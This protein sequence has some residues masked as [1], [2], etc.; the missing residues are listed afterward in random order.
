[1]DFKTELE[2]K[3]YVI[4][5]NILNTS[6][7]DKALTYFK[8]WQQNIPNHEKFSKNMNPHGIYKFHQAGHTLHAWYIRTLPQVQNIFKQLWNTEELISSFDGSCYIPKNCNKKDTCWTHTDQNGLEDKLKCYQGIVTLT[9]NKERTLVVYEGSHKLHYKYFKD[10]NNTS[11]SNWQKIDPNYLNSISDKKKILNIP[12]GSLVLWDSRTFHQNQYGKPLS[13]ERYVQYVCF[14]PKNHPQNTAAM[15]R[16]RKKYFEDRRTTS[17]WP[18]PI[19]VNG[20]QPQHFG[21]TEYIINYTKLPTIDLSE[22]M[23]KI[24]ELI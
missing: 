19:R 8:Q 21:N 17:H 7:I 9:N 11:T 22:F 2:S 20:L 1:M 23:N 16:K 24:N 4:I 14:Y 13:E 3:G 12:A 6:E 5:P 10:R 18:C 15:I